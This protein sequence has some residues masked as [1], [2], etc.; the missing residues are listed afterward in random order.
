MHRYL[1]SAF[2]ERS[3]KEQEYLI[4]GVIDSFI[5]RLRSMSDSSIDLTKWFNL[6]TFDIIGELAFG[7]SFEG[8]STGRTHSWVAA[9]MASMREGSLADTFRRFPALG[10]LYMIFHPGWLVKLTKGASQNAAYA[11]KAIDEYN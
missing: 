4:V 11:A 10:L 7:K 1:A 5:E 9:V 2:S 3:L 8:V 6:M